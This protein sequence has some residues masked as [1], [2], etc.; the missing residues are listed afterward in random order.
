MKVRAVTLGIPVDLAVEAD[1]VQQAGEV[2]AVATAALSAA[3]YPVQT[4]RLMAPPLSTV[5]AG[6]PPERLPVYAADLARAAA[7]VGFDF[8][9]L[10]PVVAT[11]PEDPLVLLDRLAEVLLADERLFASVLAAGP[12]GVHLAALRQAARIILTLAQRTPEGL[13]NLRFAVL[14]HCPPLTPFFPA[15]YHD[16]GPP[17]LALAL[18]AAD[19][20]VAAFRQARRLAEAAQRLQHA[21]LD[22]GQRLLAV[23]E[24][25]TRRFPVRFVGFDLSLA[26]FPEPGVSIVEAFEALSG[27]TFG[28]SGTLALAAWFT[29]VLRGVGLP[30]TGFSGLML[31]VLEDGLLAQRV[32]AGDVALDTLLAASAVC[33]TGLDT[34]PLPGD[35]TADQIVAILLDV[36][37]LALTL[38]KPLTARLMPVPGRAAGDRTAFTFPYFANSRIMPVPGRGLPRLAPDETFLALS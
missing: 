23:V 25:L 4:R 13:G 26:P 19:L 9:S 7:R 12:G 21:L 37:L 33:G 6:Q 15:G 17:A 8:C 11:R 18:E 35:I 30:R 3:G 1:V 29:H 10:G 28:G 38:G 32:A 34:V 20:A 14:A 36:C 2:A 5:L 27:G 16:G 24:D 22:H 31:P